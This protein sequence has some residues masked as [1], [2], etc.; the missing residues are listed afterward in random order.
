M[1]NHPFEYPV[2]TYHPRGQC[3][4]TMR[5]ATRFSPVVKLFAALVAS[6]AVADQER[7]L[8]LRH[9]DMGSGS[10]RLVFNA[11]A[12]SYGL[13]GTVAL[14]GS[15]LVFPAANL[16]RQFASIKRTSPQVS[17]MK[18][19]LIH[20]GH[21]LIVRQSQSTRNR[22]PQQRSRHSAIP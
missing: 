1:C 20:T 5:Y 3:Y 19:C 22:R 14:F 16:F 12:R 7:A 17:L 10:Y 4:E 13:W 6:L 21:I 8:I 2:A 9:H 18:W 15:R 11:C